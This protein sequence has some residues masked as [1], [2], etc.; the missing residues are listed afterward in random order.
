[1]RRSGSGV[2]VWVLGGILAL[3]G[4]ETEDAGLG[5]TLTLAA[6]GASNPT[7]A[8]D[9]QSGAALVAWVDTRD[10][11]SNVLLARI[12]PDGSVEEPVRVN[13]LP[14]DAAAHFQAPAQVAAGS[15]GEVYLLWTNNEYIA[16]R[17]FPAS[18]LRFARSS[19]GGRTFDATITVN[20]DAGGSPTSHTFHNMLVAPDGTIYL[21][22]LDSRGNELPATPMAMEHGGGDEPDPAGHAAGVVVGAAADQA[23]EDSGPDLRMAISRDGGRT[24]E[25]EVVVNRST[26]P[27]CR[28]AIAIGPD[29]EL[30]VGWREVFPGNIRD[31]VVAR[32][33]DSGVTWSEPMKV[34][35]DGWVFPGCPHAGP[36]LDVDAN[37]DLHVVWYTGKEGASGLFYAKSDNR[38]E[39]FSE[40]VPLVSAIA[41]APSLSSLIAEEDG[42]LWVSWEN[43]KNSSPELHT[44]RMSL[45]GV[46]DGIRPEII[47][48]SHP[49]LAAGAGTRVFAW[50]SGESLHAR[51]GGAVE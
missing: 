25:P 42:V 22:W 26:C 1:M 38:G 15:N 35:D 17:R 11:E 36:S 27:C 18:D 9:A 43:R 30:Y 2:V 16:G 46:R 13:D 4:C 49:S 44:V 50:L 12:S 32:S 10:G 23:P 37:G 29:G 47:S 24:F 41:V 31:V 21:S 51:V 40:P 48:G 6:R 39:A 33:D 7:T 45:D 34:H 14:G 5:A 3:A 8:V 28:T 20:D 19:D